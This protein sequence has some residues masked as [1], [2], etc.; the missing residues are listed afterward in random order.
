MN[1]L[2][3]KGFN[4]QIQSL[5]EENEKIVEEELEKKLL[6]HLQI[7]KRKNPKN[8]A[9]AHSIE[10]TSR[11]EKSERQTPDPIL[12]PFSSK[13]S[14][15]SLRIT[16]REPNQNSKFK[17]EASNNENSQRKES[18]RRKLNRPKTAKIKTI[19]KSR[20]NSAEKSK[21]N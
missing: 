9:R 13:E 15:E 10:T 19:T 17:E 7:E 12:Q 8:S 16:G 18:K 6:L 21:E 5:K 2:A 1:I 14:Q 3:S 20:P 11:R 4:S